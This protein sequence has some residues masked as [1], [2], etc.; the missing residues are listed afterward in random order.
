MR[1]SYA[2]KQNMGFCDGTH[3]ICK[4][5][6]VDSNIYHRGASL[7]IGFLLFSNA[8]IPAFGGDFMLIAT[9]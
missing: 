6:A 4:K 5:G 8:K 9:F 3:P 7:E 2:F 1:R